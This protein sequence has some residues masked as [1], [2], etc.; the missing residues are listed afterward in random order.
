M[1]KGTVSMAEY[2]RRLCQ[3]NAVVSIRQ[4]AEWG[5]KELQASF[6]RLTVKLPADARERRFMLE[7]CIRL[8]NRRT[9][10]VGVNQIRT[11]YKEVFEDN[12]ISTAVPDTN[13]LARYYGVL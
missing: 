5:M 1:D 7:T 8:Y 6:R 12:F 11:V 4:T 10:T 3:H 13:H 2:A 9:R